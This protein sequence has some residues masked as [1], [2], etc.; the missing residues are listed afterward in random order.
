MAPHEHCEIIVARD[1]VLGDPDQA[2]R[3]AIR[4]RLQK[5][6]LDHAEQCR[7]RPEAQRESNGHDKRERSVLR[8]QTGGKANIVCTVRYPMSPASPPSHVSPAGPSPGATVAIAAWC[9]DA[10]LRISFRAET[11]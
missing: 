1:T 8:Q 11:R 2:V 10:N 9:G 6:R 4:K 5:Y 3:V 7:I